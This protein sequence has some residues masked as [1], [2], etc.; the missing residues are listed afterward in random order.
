V[1]RRM[2]RREERLEVLRQIE[3]DTA[4]PA[5]FR[6]TLAEARAKWPEW[7]A[8]HNKRRDHGRT[9]ATERFGVVVADFLLRIHLPALPPPTEVVA[10]ALD[11]E[12]GHEEFLFVKRVALELALVGGFRA[13]TT[14]PTRASTHTA[15]GKV[16]LG[17]SSRCLRGRQ[18][19]YLLERV[20]QCALLWAGGPVGPATGVF[21]RWWLLRVAMND[22]GPRA[23]SCCS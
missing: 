16:G 11:L 12:C 1:D 19:A 6:L 14:S 10:Y 4:A 17:P 13:R 18:W 7:A 9:A 22:C 5:P 3:E 23:R 20:R 2:R 21:L 15:S 8:A